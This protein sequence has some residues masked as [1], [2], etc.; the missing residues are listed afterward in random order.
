MACVPNGKGGYKRV[1]WGDVNA[2]VTGK[3]GNTDVERRRLEQ[4]IIAI[5]VSVVIIQHDVWPVEIGD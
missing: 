1:H 5:P 3:S 4:G 2:K